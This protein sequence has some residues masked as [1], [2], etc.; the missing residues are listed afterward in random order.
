MNLGS[1]IDT[2]KPAALNVSDR[3][4]ISNGWKQIG[5]ILHYGSNIHYVSDASKLT[6]FHVQHETSV[7]NRKQICCTPHHMDLEFCSR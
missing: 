7:C 1:V 3:T 2:N 5:Y 4:L 6:A